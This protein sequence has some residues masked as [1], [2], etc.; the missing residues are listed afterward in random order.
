MDSLIEPSRWKTL[1]QSLISNIKE[2]SK[3]P[4]SKSAA[5][6]ESNPASLKEIEELLAAAPKKLDSLAKELG[7]LAGNAKEL[8]KSIQDWLEGATIPSY[9][10]ETRD[11]FIERVNKLNV[12]QSC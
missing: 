8:Q 2:P 3:K 9:D 11:S 5:K 7:Q 10:L 1:A 4:N 12:D 6:E